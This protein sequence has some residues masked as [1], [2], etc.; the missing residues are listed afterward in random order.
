[1]MRVIAAVVTVSLS[2]MIYDNIRVR[3]LDLLPVLCNMD[4]LS[5]VSAS[6][7]KVLTVIRT[8]A[9]IVTATLLLSAL[10]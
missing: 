5:V 10:T 1:M 9:E 6:I 8:T 4:P 7:L 3:F 2:L